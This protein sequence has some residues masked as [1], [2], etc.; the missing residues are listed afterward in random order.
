MEALRVVLLFGCAAWRVAAV[1]AAQ[2]GRPLEV[3]RVTPREAWQIAVVLGAARGL[4]PQL[5]G[6]Y[7]VGEKVYFSG[8]SQ[9]VANGD[10]LVHG[11]QGEVVGPG[12]LDGYVGTAVAVQ[13]A[14]NKGAI[15]CYLKRVRRQRFH[16]PLLHVP[17]PL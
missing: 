8:D 14:G 7:K 15:E 12:T 6:G 11:K 9:T 17:P 4:E 16:R 2:H 13:F 5:P 10:K 3:R 1:G